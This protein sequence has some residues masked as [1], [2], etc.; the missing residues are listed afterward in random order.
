MCVYVCGLE[1]V[2]RKIC[3]M[4]RKS[5]E[6]DQHVTRQTTDIKNDEKK[7]KAAHV[8]SQQD[9]ITIANSYPGA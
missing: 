2:A 6:A 9:G 5:D 1:V 4:R 8:P 7:R 3:S